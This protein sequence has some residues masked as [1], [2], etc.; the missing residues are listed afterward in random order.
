MAMTQ[1]IFQPDQ[2]F[3]IHKWWGWQRLH[4]HGC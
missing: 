2:C 3:F 1:R 4:P